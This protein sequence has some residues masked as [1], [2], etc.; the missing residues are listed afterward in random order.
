M[1]SAGLA[2]GVGVDAGRPVWS[3]DKS[4]TLTR[5][6]AVSRTMLTAMGQLMT[7]LSPP[8]K[9]GRTVDGDGPTDYVNRYLLPVC[10]SKPLSEQAFA[11]DPV[12]GVCRS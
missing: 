8:R 5:L 6:R 7:E 1:S 4:W 12:H 10:Q 11:N 9:L 2:T 3:T